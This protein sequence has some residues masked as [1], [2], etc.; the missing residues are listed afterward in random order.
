MDAAVLTHA[1]RYAGRATNRNL[2]LGREP[3]KELD[4][5][6][7]GVSLGRED[8]GGFKKGRVGRVPAKPPFN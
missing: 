3:I 1:D 6:F 8:V 7:K 2:H 5:G 4:G